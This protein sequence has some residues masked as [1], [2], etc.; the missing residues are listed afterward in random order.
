MPSRWKDF[1]LGPYPEGA[2]VYAF[3]G[4]AGEVVYIG[5]ARNL[6][7]RMSGHKRAGKMVGVASV[8]ARRCVTSGEMASL[9]VRLIERLRPRRNKLDT[10]PVVPLLE[11]ASLKM[12]RDLVQLNVR[13]P[14]DLKAELLACPLVQQIGWSAVFSQALNELFALEP[15]ASV[16]AEARRQVHSPSPSPPST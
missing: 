9:E 10:R 15:Y 3:V 12:P 16:I 13:I 8:K 4:A 5:K 1:K 2:A 14:V 11:L 7:N 6:N